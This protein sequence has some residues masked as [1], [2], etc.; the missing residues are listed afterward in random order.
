MPGLFGTIR[1]DVAHLC[2][3]NARIKRN[4]FFF[5]MFLRPSTLTTLKPSKVVFADSV[6]QDQTAQNVHSDLDLHCPLNCY[7]P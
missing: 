7:M 1:V 2:C 6:G 3:K 4:T 5:F